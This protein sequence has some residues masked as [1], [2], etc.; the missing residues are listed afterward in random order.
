MRSRSWD[1]ATCWMS[2]LSLDVGPYNGVSGS[3]SSMTVLWGAGG[4]LREAVTLDLGK[5][6][7]LSGARV[8]G[9]GQLAGI[10]VLVSRNNTSF[11]HLAT[12]EVDGGRLALGRVRARYVRLERAGASE[13]AL[14]GGLAEL[15]LA[16]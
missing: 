11:I 5:E 6:Y 10:R 4:V 3:A 1:G 2:R 7:I 8:W 12:V 16:G 15:E 13:T 14:E 9:L